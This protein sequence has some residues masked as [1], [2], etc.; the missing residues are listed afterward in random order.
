MLWLPGSRAAWTLRRARLFLSRLFLL[1][2]I[3]LSR[4]TGGGGR[5]LRD[6]DGPIRRARLCGDR[7]GQV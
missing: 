4:R 6:D 1:T 5:C 2:R 3:R 7:Q